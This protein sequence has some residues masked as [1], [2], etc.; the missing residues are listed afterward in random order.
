MSEKLMRFLDNRLAKIQSRWALAGYMIL[1]MIPAAT[2]IVLFAVLGKDFVED[3]VQISL[4]NE[5]LAF[6]GALATLLVAGP[7]IRRDKELSSRDHNR[8]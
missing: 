6:A 4:P 1:V 8:S 2:A 3:I 5:F 7:F